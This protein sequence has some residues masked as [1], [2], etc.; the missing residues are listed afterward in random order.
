MPPV[1]TVSNSW[2]AQQLTEFLVAVSGLPDEEAA[3]RGAADRVAETFDAEAVAMID[4]DGNVVAAG[5]GSVDVPVA[6]LLAVARGSEELEIP[7]VGACRA[8]CEPIDDPHLENL[9][10]ARRTPAF[11]AEERSLVQ[12]L[13]RVLGLTVQLLRSAATERAMREVSELQRIENVRLLVS[14]RERERLLKRLSRIQN[15]IVSRRALDEVLD[16][17]VTGARDLLGDETV[18]LRL[19]DAEDPETLVMVASAGVKPELV[20]EQQRSPLGQGAGGRAAAEGELVVIEDYAGDEHSL[21]AFAADGIRAALAAPV[22]EHGEVV[23]S[24]VVATHRTGRRYSDAEREMLVAFAEHASLAL[25]YAKTVEDAL[26]QAL[27]DSLTGLPN[28]VLLRDR[29]DQALERAARRPGRVA[30]LF[31]DL[32]AFKT[33]NDSLG[34][35]AGDELL[36]EAARRILGCIRSSDTAARF[37]GDEFV[38]VLED[39]DEHEVASI[40]AR[41]LAELERPFE[42]RGRELPIGAS[43]G[44][45]VS[46]DEDDDLLRNADLALY[47][48]KAAGGGRSEIYEPRMH[49]AVIERIELESALSKALREDELALHYQPIVDLETGS[50]EGVEALARWRHPKRGL[51]L[52]GEFVPVAEDG[53][54]IVP[55]GRWVLETSCRQVASW[56]GHGAPIL[57]VNVSSAQLQGDGLPEDIAAALERSGLAPD[58]LVLELTETAFLGEVDATVERLTEL[59]EL[60]VRLAVDD[61]GTGNASLRHLTRFP[62]DILKIDR[63]FVADI[64]TNTAETVIARSIIELGERLALTVIGEGIETEAQRQELLG[65]GCRLGQ[66]FHLANPGPL[67]ELGRAPQ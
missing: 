64:G 2:V 31:V 17:I 27:H 7:G 52:P 10:L 15:S 44:I 26:Q 8:I 1:A 66:G 23:G 37:G 34:H 58:R 50:L 19:V 13:A 61:F 24:L 14:L 63:S 67:E 12:G 59:K 22:R 29:L 3:I 39:A 25:T 4:S 54:L 9:V 49:T 46:G 16:G 51:L 6:G 32:D 30:A 48:A 36:V 35:A 5:F 42:V 33:V 41:I 53:R 65:L 11:S 40:A 62:I 45:A 20:R 38:V 18:G 28:R 47:R 56:D 55:L 21:P 43:I 60:G 57:S